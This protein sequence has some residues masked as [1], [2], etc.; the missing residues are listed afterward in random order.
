VGVRAQVQRFDALAFGTRE[1]L[2]LAI[3]A[4]DEHDF[5]GQRSGLA[6]VNDR[7]QNRSPVGS[8]YGQMVH[9]AT[10]KIAV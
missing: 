10:L 8:E 5:G 7:L 6:S 4:D 9:E 1:R 3:V 2:R